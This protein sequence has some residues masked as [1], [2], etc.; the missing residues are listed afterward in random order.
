ML[1]S[2]AFIVLNPP[3]ATVLWIEVIVYL[4]IGL[5][6]FFDD[7]F[8]RPKPWMT[9]NGK[10]NGYL[11]LQFLGGHKMH[12]TTCILLGFVALNGLIENR[13][14]RFEIEFIF[15]SLAL[16]MTLVWSSKFPGRLGVLVI[17]CK[18]E[19]WLQIAMFALYVQWIRPPVAMICIA[20]NIWGIFLY[21]IRSKHTFFVPHAPE[22]V[23][24]DVKDAMGEEAAAKIRRFV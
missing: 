18:P 9:L 21:F 5:F 10:V 4:G 23:V 13:V 11:R 17:A 2:N 6:E 7:F 3:L 19:F 20:L 24:Q 1:E 15:L 8:E 12:A 14:S 22:T 16:I